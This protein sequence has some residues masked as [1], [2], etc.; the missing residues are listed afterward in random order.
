MALA[1]NGVVQMCQLVPWQFTV[2][3]FSLCSTHVQQTS[4]KHPWAYVQ[5]NPDL[6]FLGCPT[7]IW[8]S[9]SRN[10]CHSVYALVKHLELQWKLPGFSHPLI[11]VSS[12]DELM[13]TSRVQNSE[14]WEMSSLCSY[15][16][17][18]ANCIAHTASLYLV[19]YPWIS[20][21]LLH[22]TKRNLW[23]LFWGKK[24]FCNFP[25]IF[26]AHSARKTRAGKTHSVISL[27]L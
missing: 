27:L 15:L 7:L 24:N 4:I 23:I 25:I 18:K 11:L 3:Q 5:K 20:S 1:I 10:A 19:L 9:S 8:K 13:E 16:I 21:I 14:R 26:C 2:K 6:K 22:L 17:K 12:I